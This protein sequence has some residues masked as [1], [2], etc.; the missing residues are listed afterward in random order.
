M[1]PTTTTTPLPTT[2][3]SGYDAEGA[4]DGSYDA[5][6]TEDGRRRAKITTHRSKRAH[7]PPLP[8]RRSQYSRNIGGV[9]THEQKPQ[10]ATY[11]Q[12]ALQ[13]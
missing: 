13:H 4:E 8:R 3:R 7:L 10:L 1:L 6:G 11:N 5:E 12:H 2:G 9:I